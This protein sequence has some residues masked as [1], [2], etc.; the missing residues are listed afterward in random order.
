MKQYIPQR[1]KEKIRLNAHT[2][3]VIRLPF[4]DK[5]IKDPL[6]VL[7]EFFCKECNKNYKWTQL[8]YDLGVS[9]PMVTVNNKESCIAC[10]RRRL[11]ANKD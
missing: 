4:Q 11:R 8:H 5:T 10:V 7:K 3:Q 9:P 6:K 2:K 1:P